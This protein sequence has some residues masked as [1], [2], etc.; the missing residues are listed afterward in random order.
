M[1]EQVLLDPGADAVSEQ[2]AVGDDDTRAAAVVAAVPRPV[3]A[4]HDELEKQR[5]GLDGGLVWGKFPRMPLSL[6]M[7]WRAD[8]MMEPSCWAVV[9]ILAV[10]VRGGM[11][12]RARSLLRSLS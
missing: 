3:Q 10:L 9:T 4:T 6:R 2:G 11:G 5:R 7:I 8:L 12:Q 1:L